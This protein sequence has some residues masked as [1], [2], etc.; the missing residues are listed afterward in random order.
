MYFFHY[1]LVISVDLGHQIMMFMMLP[2]FGKFD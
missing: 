2:E 1:V